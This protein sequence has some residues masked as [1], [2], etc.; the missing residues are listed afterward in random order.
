M[1]SFMSEHTAEYALVGDLM[2]RLNPTFPH[3]VPMYF[4]ASREGDTMAR[5]AF[6]G[7]EVRLVAVFPRRPKVFSPH[8][9][10]V[11]VKFNSSVLLHAHIARAC[12]I[13]VLAGVPLV[14]DLSEFR[15]DSKCAWF[16]VHGAK[17]GDTDLEMLL[18]KCG[19]IAEHTGR[20][21]T[22]SGPAH[23][24]DILRDLK[25]TCEAGVW[26]SWLRLIRE[27]RKTVCPERGRFLWSFPACKPFYLAILE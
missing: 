18:T 22:V 19:E 8:D 3:V 27:I 25:E 2:N 9:D 1:I 4:W 20:L 24:E 23:T 7:K 16:I 21:G 26:D 17:T 10:H 15:I 6:N 11:L 5:E 14:S 12:G 13:A